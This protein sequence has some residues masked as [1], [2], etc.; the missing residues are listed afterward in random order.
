MTDANSI[1]IEP[2]DTLCHPSCAPPRRNK[3][4]SPA[5]PNNETHGQVSASQQ[6]TAEPDT[7]DAD[8]HS[9]LHAAFYGYTNRVR[10][11]PPRQIP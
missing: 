7:R 3:E 10:I 4:G 1:V 6:P 2:N 5:M 11:V 8:R 9:P